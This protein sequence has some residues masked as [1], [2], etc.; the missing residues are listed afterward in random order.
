MIEIEAKLE[1][2]EKFRDTHGLP[3]LY[4][5][6]NVAEIVGLWEMMDFESAWA[7]KQNCGHDHRE[8]H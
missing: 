6:R 7:N 3:R 8:P 5:K 2:E 4:P 1:I